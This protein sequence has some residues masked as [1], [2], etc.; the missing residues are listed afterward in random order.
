[1]PNEKIDRKKKKKGRKTTA[2]REYR[3]AKN[4]GKAMADGRSN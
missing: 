2:V 4:G 1:M 3:G